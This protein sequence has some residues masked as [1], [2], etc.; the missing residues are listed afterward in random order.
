MRH[1]QAGALLEQLTGNMSC[2]AGTACAERQLVRIGPRVLQQLGEVLGRQDRMGDQHQPDISQFGD[3][4]EVV[5]GV[6]WNIG[7]G[8][9]IDHHGGIQPEQ[10]GVAIWRGASHILRPYAAP[11]ACTVFYNDRLA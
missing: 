6:K 11:S 1:V 5:D 7:L 3:R 4:Y 8:E 9:G 2:A 10:Q